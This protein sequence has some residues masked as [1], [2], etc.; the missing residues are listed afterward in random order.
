LTATIGSRTPLYGGAWG[1]AIMAFLPEDMIYTLF[2]QGMEKLT[3]NTIT[4]PE[5]LLNDLKEIKQNGWCYSEGEYADNTAG[6]AVPI[7]NGR[8]Q[9]VGSLTAAGPDYRIGPDRVGFI[10]E[11]LLQGRD[12]IQKHIQNLN[13]T[14]TDLPIRSK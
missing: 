4:S 5:K 8:H 12:E 13:F 11:C 7:F 2:D 14:Y 3:A 1:K 6:I 9:I 10:L